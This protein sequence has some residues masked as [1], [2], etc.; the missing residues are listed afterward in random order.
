MHLFAGPGG[1]E[2]GERLLDLDPDAAVGVEVD[3]V[4][5]A[6]AVAAGHPRIVADVTA[7]DPLEVAAGRPVGLLWGSPPCQDDSVTNR[8]GRRGVAALKW[9]PIRWIRALDPV[10]VGL[11]QVPSVLPVWQQYAV[12]LRAY[13]YSVWTGLLRADRYGAGQARERAVLLARRD[14]TPVAPPAP[15]HGTVLAPTLFED[16]LE[17]PLVTGAAALGWS[18]AD[19]HAHVWRGDPSEGEW[20]LRR[21]ATTVT[22]TNRLAPPGYRTHG[23]PQF[24]PGSIRLDVADMARL[25]TF[26]DGY[27]WAG[28]VTQQRQQI[29]NAVPPLLAAHVLSALGLGAYRQEIAA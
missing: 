15:T 26:R 12:M 1:V 28:T 24:G 13:G 27:P 11:E 4:A 19:V 21:P 25:Q 22:G 14:G 18:R 5:S 9:E 10:A 6:T 2:E 8:R 17:V 23:M 29:G 16:T 3:P 7:L 20:L